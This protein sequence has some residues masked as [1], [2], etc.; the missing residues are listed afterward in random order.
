MKTGSEAA[1]EGVWRILRARHS[2]HEKKKKKNG[3]G[4]SK[5][6]EFLSLVSK[7]KGN[8]HVPAHK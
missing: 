3:G 2:T 4:A 8:V 1:D 7:K 5:L 6:S